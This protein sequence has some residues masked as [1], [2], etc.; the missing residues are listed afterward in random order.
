MEKKQNSL[1]CNLNILRRIDHAS[2]RHC[3]PVHTTTGTAPI[4]IRNRPRL[5]LLLRTAQLVDSMGSPLRRAQQAAEDPEVAGT[6]VQI[7][8]HHSLP[9]SYRDK[10]CLI[11]CFRSRSHGAGLFR[12]GDGSTVRDSSELSSLDDGSG[13]CLAVFAVG[14]GEGYRAGD[15]CAGG[16]LGDAV[17]GA[18]LGDV[19]V[20]FGDGGGGIGSG[21]RESGG[22]REEGRG[23]RD[24]GG[25]V[26]AGSCVAICW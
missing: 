6:G 4:T 14:R 21:L 2:N 1:R 19:E 25:D 7:Q 10:V 24:G 17:G 18:E 8:I 9:N 16:D 11:I 23:G 20:C 26:H 22:E 5:A 3:I 15:F 12:C 13:S